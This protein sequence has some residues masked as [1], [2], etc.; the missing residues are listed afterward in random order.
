MIKKFDAPTGYNYYGTTFGLED[1]SKGHVHLT[2]HFVNYDGNDSVDIESEIYDPEIAAAYAKA[3]AI[4]GIDFG[5]YKVVN[6]VP[7]TDELA[8]SEN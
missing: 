4:E 7:L 1:E 6:V 3:N 8:S 2:S 5:T